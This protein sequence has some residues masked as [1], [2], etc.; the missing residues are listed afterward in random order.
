MSTIPRHTNTSVAI[1]DEKT[2]ITL[3]FAT[4]RRGSYRVKPLH[5][6]VSLSNGESG[7]NYHRDGDNDLQ[8]ADW[9]G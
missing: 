3:V 5:S 8:S 7:D 2:F 9:N 6:Q 4:A 1:P